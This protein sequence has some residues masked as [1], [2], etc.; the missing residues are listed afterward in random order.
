MQL[1]SYIVDLEIRHPALDPDLVSRILGLEPGIAWR[2]GEPRRTPKGTPLEGVRSEGYWSANPFSY[3]WRESTDAQVEDTL[4]EL[5]SFLEPHKDFLLS[6]GQAGAVFPKPP[7]PPRPR[8]C[9]AP[10]RG[11]PARRRR[12]RIR[13]GARR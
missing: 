1:Y 13:A 2:A 7:A 9:A 3:G 4:V 12:T 11:A 8:S 10:D 5:V 6:L